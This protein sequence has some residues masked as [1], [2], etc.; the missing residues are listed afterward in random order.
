[1]SKQLIINGLE[2]AHGAKALHGKITLRDLARLHDYLHNLDEVIDY[3]L[4]GL[5]TKHNEP[6]LALKLKGRLELICQRCLKP[7]EHPVDIQ[8][9]FKLV[10]DA[11]ELPDIIEED[12]S[13]DNLVT[14]SQ[15]D[16]LAL[17][18]EEIILALPISARHALDNCEENDYT[19][20]KDDQKNGVNPV[21]ASLSSLK[22]V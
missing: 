9:Q 18:E 5:A 8:A 21:F 4:S 22:K 10:S 15:L 19:D 20:F 13:I 6:L 16:V 1:M 7:M 3:T 12:A 11:K 17:M 2:F 14:D